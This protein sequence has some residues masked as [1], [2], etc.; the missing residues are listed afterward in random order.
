MGAIAKLAHEMAAYYSEQKLI[1]HLIESE[2]EILQEVG[3]EVL[4]EEGFPEWTRLSDV[5]YVVELASSYSFNEWA[6]LAKA[7]FNIENIIHFAKNEMYD[8]FTEFVRL[9]D[10]NV[11][12][13]TDPNE[14]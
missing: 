4:N 7:L 14:F 9:F 8:L 1:N 10:I 6:E 12:I 2:N 5:N 11:K 13:K 3:Q